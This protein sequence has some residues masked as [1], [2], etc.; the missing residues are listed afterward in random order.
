MNNYAK[1]LK[2][3]SFLLGGLY[4][5]RPASQQGEAV[6]LAVGHSLHVAPFGVQNQVY[7]APD[8]SGK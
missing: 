2:I 5:E 8:I 6:G 3:S 4:E 7:F 1:S